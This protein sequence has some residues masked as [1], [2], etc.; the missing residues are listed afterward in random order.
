MMARTPFLHPE[1]RTG[2]LQWK[3]LLTHGLISALVVVFY[4]TKKSF[5]ISIHNPAHIILF[6]FSFVLMTLAAVACGLVSTYLD[7]Y[8]PWYQNMPFRR[9][10]QVVFGVVLVSLIALQTVYLSYQVLLDI[11]LRETE[12]FS[13]D[14]T[15][16]M[17]CIVGINFH[18]HNLYLRS[19]I[20][21]SRTGQAGSERLPIPEKALQDELNTPFFISGRTRPIPA[22]RTAAL[23]LHDV[24]KKSKVVR[25]VEWDGTAHILEDTYA[26]SGIEQECPFIFFK[27]SRDYLINRYAL[28]GVRMSGDKKYE[29]LLHIPE[30]NSLSIS[31]N[32]YRELQSLFETT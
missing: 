29:L 31:R 18:H 23:Y 5:F 1:I 15:A 19:L 8:C 16:V 27:V 6:V 24:G 21:S 7:R 26:L 9:I 17:A 22:A 13:R 30:I 12:Y 11:N 25:L 2:Y 4:T 20:K 3:Y 10:L 14:F 28:A 32:K